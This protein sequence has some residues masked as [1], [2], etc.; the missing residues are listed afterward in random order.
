MLISMD[1]KAATNMLAIKTILGCVPALLKMSVA[2]RLSILHL[3]SAAARVKPP[4]SSMMTGLHIEAKIASVACFELRRLWD[5]P[6][7]SSRTT[8]RTTD[9]NG[10]SSEVTNSGMVWAVLEST[11][12]DFSVRHVPR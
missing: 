10:M 12:S 3:E 9:R 1:A 11:F 6:L 2:S 5:L 8:L 7:P 4:S